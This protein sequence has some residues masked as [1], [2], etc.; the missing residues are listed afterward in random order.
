MIGEVDCCGFSPLKW[1][2]MGGSTPFPSFMGLLTIGFPYRRPY[3]GFISGGLALG[4]S[5]HDTF[6]KTHPT[7]LY[8]GHIYS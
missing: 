4:G 2:K 3:Y 5:C 7:K 1:I 8:V 6:G